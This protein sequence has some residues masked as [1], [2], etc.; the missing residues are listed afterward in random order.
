MHMMMKNNK[1]ALFKDFAATLLPHEVEYLENVSRFK[2]KDNVQILDELKRCTH[3]VG[4]TFSMDKNI[5]KRKYAYVKKWILNKLHAI[6]ADDHFDYI[7]RLDLK[8]MTDALHPEDETNILSLIASAQPTDYYFVRFYELVQN[9][10]YYLLIRMRHNYLKAINTFLEEKQ[11]FWLRSREISLELH[12]ATVDIVDQYASNKKESIQWEERLIT[13]FNDDSLDGLNRYYAIV[14]LTFIYYN[15]KL[16]SKLEK[17]YNRL[18]ALIV[19]G[20]IYSKRILVNY[21]ANRVLLHARNDELEKAVY[22]GLLSIR[23]KSADY[24]FYLGNLCAVM[25]RANRAKEALVLMKENLTELK[26]TISPHNRIGFASYYVQTL[27]RCGK[28]RQALSYATTFLEINRNDIL[29]FRW[30]LFFSSM[31]LAMLFEERYTEMIKIVKKFQ[32][33][34]RDK[35]QQERSGYL[36]VIDWFY[37]VALYK[38][39]HI[40]EAYFFNLLRRYFSE[41]MPEGHK[42]KQIESL[43]NDIR[44]HLN[45]MPDFL[46]KL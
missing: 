34:D 44:P 36:P 10:R 42:R 4:S 40:D 35:V 18:D 32:L 43:L 20:L 3:Q 22:Y 8:I 45:G 29:Q 12:E 28:S 37:H 6:D 7:S 24:V 11:E 21:Y 25:L 31:L 16:Y 14:R 41:N 17:L 15:Y 39:C 5:D 9:Y 27:V 33:L 13:I 30:H 46:N 26:K 1:R 38:E 19:Q 23:W 2:E